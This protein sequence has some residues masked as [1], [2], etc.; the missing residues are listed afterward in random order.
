[1]SLWFLIRLCGKKISYL[2]NQTIISYFS[3]TI[4]FEDLLNSSPES[5]VAEIEKMQS[6]IQPDAG[7]N[8]QFTSGTT[9]QPK[10]A[11]N[12]HFSIVNSAH[13]IALRKEQHRQHRHLCSMFPFFHTAGV[14]TIV[15]TMFNGWTIVLPSPHFSA[16]LSLKTLSKLRCQCLYGTPSSE[17]SIIL[18]IKELISFLQCTST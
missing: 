9:G 16:E 15:N 18:K 13:G 7:C 3:G 8:L 1:M 5:D 14:L 11:L 10:A 2:W 6:T 17:F 12:S 4:K